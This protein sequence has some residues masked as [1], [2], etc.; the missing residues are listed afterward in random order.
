MAYTV[1]TKNSDNNPQQNLY[2]LGVIRSQHTLLVGLCWEEQSHQNQGLTRMPYYKGP[3]QK[4]LYP[5]GFPQ[6]LRRK[7]VKEEKKRKEPSSYLQI[8]MLMIKSYRW[9][10][11][12]SEMFWPEAKGAKSS[13]LLRFQVLFLGG[14]THDF[15]TQLSNFR[16]AVYT[17]A[18]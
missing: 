10:V 3:K 13:D 8:I 2:H 11:I 14:V 16:G 4:C 5:L 17:L 12:I 1:Y 15:I 18:F 6:Q 7:K 9:R